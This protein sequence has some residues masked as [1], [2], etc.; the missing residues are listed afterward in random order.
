MAGIVF[1][2]SAPNYLGYAKRK[3]MVNGFA[4]FGEFSRSFLFLTPRK[5]ALEAF[6][7][8]FTTYIPYS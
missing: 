4:V 5:N 6:F 8:A 7:T 1:F 2:Q 3:F